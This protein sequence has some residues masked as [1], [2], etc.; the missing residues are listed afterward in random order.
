MR[1]IH[2]GC[3]AAAVLSLWH[4]PAAAGSPPLPS[5]DTIS[6]GIGVADYD[7]QSG[8]NT[9]TAGFLVR[10]NSGQLALFSAGH[11]DE[12][13]RVDVNLSGSYTT[14]GTFTASIH[15]GDA[16]GDTDIGLISLMPGL[17]VTPAVVGAEP[18]RGAT[19]HVKM[20]ETLCKFGLTT[21]RQCGP[22]TNITASKVTFA[23]PTQ[24]GDSGGPVYAINPDGSGVTAVGITTGAT[25]GVGSAPPACGSA[26][27]FSVAELIQPWLRKWA[28]TVQTS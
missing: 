11:C 24:C 21:D 23:A 25:M 22:V 26:S 10:T 8:G 28:V 27:T 19:D 2:L 1:I 7:G 9:C 16:A 15:Q 14:I 4:P 17:P 13:G 12:G 20:G 18:V 6:P 3:T 5:V